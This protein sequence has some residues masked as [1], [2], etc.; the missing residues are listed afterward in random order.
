MQMANFPRSG[1]FKLDHFPFQVKVV[2]FRADNYKKFI[3]FKFIFIE[4]VG[5]YNDLSYMIKNV[6]IIN[7]SAL[8]I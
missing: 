2:F 5:L 7:I 4:L 3:Y 6:C 1:N 8:S